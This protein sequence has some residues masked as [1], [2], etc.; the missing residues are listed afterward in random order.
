MVIKQT[1]YPM[2]IYSSQITYLGISNW[3]GHPKTLTEHLDLEYL[4]SHK[5]L[6]LLKKH[7]EL[8]QGLCHPCETNSC[9]SAQY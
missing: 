3:G 2:T 6:L 7:K 8:T 1:K 9:V 4:K 5:E